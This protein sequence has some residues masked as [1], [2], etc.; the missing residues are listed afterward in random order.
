M[1]FND[2]RADSVD[3]NVRTREEDQSAERNVLLLCL[4]VLLES[5]VD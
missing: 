3:S 2:L 4:F 1:W 5:S